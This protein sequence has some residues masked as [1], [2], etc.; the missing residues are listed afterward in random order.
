[1]PSCER[2]FYALSDC[3]RK[4]ECVKEQ[5]HKPSECIQRLLRAKVQQQN[6]LQL[7]KDSTNNTNTN[8]NT[9][10]SLPAHD[11]L[12]IHKV[13]KTKNSDG[14]ETINIAWECAHQH[15]SY[16]ECMYF[17]SNPRNRFRPAYGSLG[18]NASDADEDNT[19]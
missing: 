8:T 14:G 11:N 15:Q 10:D 19:K 6:G 18:V 5:K 7:F 17:N 16:M 2:F 1:M 9:H 13:D 12:S 3:I 4:S